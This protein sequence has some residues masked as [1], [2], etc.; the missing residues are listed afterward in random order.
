[1]S[2]TGAG[3]LLCIGDVRGCVRELER[4]LLWSDAGA[5][6]RATHGGWLSAFDLSRGEVLKGRRHSLDLQ[7][8]DVREALHPL[9]PADAS[10]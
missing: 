2:K 3:R 4:L 1:M 8:Q 9:S 7:P 6:D 10:A 5:G